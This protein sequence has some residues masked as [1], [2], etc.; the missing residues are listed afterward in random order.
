MGDLEN[1]IKV[2][3]DMFEEHSG[4]DSDCLNE[5]E[6]KRMMSEKFTASDYKG[7]LNLSDLDEA[8]DKVDKNDNGEINF[9]EYVRCMCMLMKGYRRKNKRGCKEGRGRKKGGRGGNDD[10]D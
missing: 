4:E 1:A 6:F 5:E 7:K 9:A 3:V 8:F 10:E 2:I